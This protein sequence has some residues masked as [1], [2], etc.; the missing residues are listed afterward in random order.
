MNAAKV[1]TIPPSEASIRVENDAMPRE[2]RQFLTS[3]PIADNH[4]ENQ[5]ACRIENPT[6]E[7]QSQKTADGV[8]IQHREVRAERASDWHPEVGATEGRVEQRCTRKPHNDTDDRP[9][10]HDTCASVEAEF[11]RI[12]ISS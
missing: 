8:K 11:R 2:R 9:F 1:F 5:Q 12:N 6:K 4:G 7:G 10:L 3:K